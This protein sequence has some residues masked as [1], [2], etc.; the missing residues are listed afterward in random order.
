MY[1]NKFTVGYYKLKHEVVKAGLFQEVFSPVHNH[2]TL[3]SHLCHSQ[4]FQ[5]LKTYKL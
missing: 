1:K 3:P 4:S 2:C 5:F